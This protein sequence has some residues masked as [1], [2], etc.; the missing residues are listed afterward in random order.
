MQQGLVP[1]SVLSV[2]SE[3]MDCPFPLRHSWAFAASM[4][5]VR[6]FNQLIFQRFVHKSS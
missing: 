6:H 4:M 1:L 5:D 3:Q 2:L